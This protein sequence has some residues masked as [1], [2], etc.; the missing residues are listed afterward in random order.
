MFCDF[1]RL[2]VGDQV[3]IVGK[4]FSCSKCYPTAIDT[5][6][7]EE[8]LKD[9]E[10]NRT[11]HLKQFI[12]LLNNTNQTDISNIR[13][14]IMH[15]ERVFIFGN[16]ASNSMASHFATDL[17]KNKG[18]QAFT[19]SDAALLT[20]LNNDYG[21]DMAYVRYLKTMQI[22]KMDTVIFISSSGNSPNLV[23]ALKYIINETNCYNTIALT[24]FDKDNFL[25]ISTYRRIH[26]PNNSYGMVESAHAYFI[27]AILDQIGDVK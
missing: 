13:N 15:S 19:V 3:S 9:F 24:G 23:N 21:S 5:Y 25:N 7:A 11:T 17:I 27:H 2:N 8:K 14:A 10:T 6:I 1:C 20:C 18:I 16:G 12:D 4:K 26:C 22:N